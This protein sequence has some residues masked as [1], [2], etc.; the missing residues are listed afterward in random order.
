MESFVQ[1]LQKFGYGRLA[2]IIGVAVGI[3]LALT[4]VLNSLA[5]KPEALLYS[6]LDLKEASQITTALTAAG[7]KY[8]ARGDGSMIMVPREKVAEARLMLSSKGL[9]TS[10]SVGYEL[11]DNAPALGQTEFVQNLNRQRAL[12]GELAK[13]IRGLKGVTS[14]RV[15]LSLPKRELFQEEAAQPTASVVIGLSN[16]D[17]SPDNIRAIRNL[18]AS[19]V[20]NLK[21]DAVSLIDDKNR[22]LAAGGTEAD[23]GVG[24]QFAAQRK[25]E[26][27][28][29][30]RKRLK[31]LVEGIVGPGNARITVSADLDQD[32]IT[33]QEE[34]FDPDGQVVRST[35]TTQS[36]DS[37]SEPSPNGQT[38]AGA[39]VP[40][41]GQANGANATSQKG[42]QQETTNYEISKAVTTT[43][44]EP[45]AIK[46]LAV[47]VVVD[48]VT[49]VAK[50]GKPGAYQ[51]RSA[52]DMQRIETLVKAAV[53]FDQTRGDQ[54]QVLNVKFNRDAG[55]L[56]G[57]EAANPMF[58]FDK[59]DIM[60]AVEIGILLIVALMIIFFVAQPL[61]KST[62]PNGGQ[63]TP[64]QT[65]ALP[66]GG[67]V[68]V[69]SDGSVV[70]AL[71]TPTGEGQ[72]AL[73]SPDSPGIESKLDMA[74]IEGQV[75]ASSIKKVSEFIA[76]HPEES[77]AILR[78]WLN[79]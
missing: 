4:V 12:E 39:N 1:G 47:A 7:I 58:A 11:F 41:A 54:V 72:M 52:E 37:S 73:P 21:A 27:E 74:R 26:I 63:P 24:G 16:G 78:S 46:K 18:V 36:S 66:G 40:P 32:R 64:T 61:I 75:K 57:V 2:A 8:E 20:P 42:D 59:N 51:P 6:N 5:T 43:V 62:L 45:G 33:K 35:S 48:G 79:E 55:A 56:G 38:T 23:T 9:P 19:A 15:H 14:A 34:K 17:L 67:V 29:Q 10:G 3:A 60:R 69:M 65:M 28:D 77:V 71:P 22:L 31:D 70:Q 44:T 50:G 53:G 13:T 68:T 25:A 49:P 30:M 76:A